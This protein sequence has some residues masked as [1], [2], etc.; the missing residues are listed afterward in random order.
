MSPTA[1]QASFS[2]ICTR[3]VSLPVQ[4]DHS[5]SRCSMQF[6]R[7]CTSVHPWGRVSE[8]QFIKDECAV[9]LAYFVWQTE[10]NRS[11]L[12]HAVHPLALCV[13]SWLSAEFRMC[14][15]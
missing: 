12:M 11:A 5:V 15:W 3:I 9:V 8:M 7:L 13:V 4:H 10:C 6:T 14:A 2:D 1:L